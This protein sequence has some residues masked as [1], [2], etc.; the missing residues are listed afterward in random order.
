MCG[1]WG[2]LSLLRNLSSIRSSAFNSFYQ[3]KYRGPDRSHFFELN[4]LHSSINF[5][6]GFHRLAI[7]DTST[8]GDQPFVFEFN[9]HTV[10]T[11]CNGEIFNSHQLIN[12]YNLNLLSHSDCE[13]IPSI[14]QQ[15]G[16]HTLVQDLLGEFACAIFD[17]HSDNTAQIFLFRDPFGVR[18]LFY[19]L[20]DN[21]FAFA[22]EAKAIQDLVTNI[23]PFP[24]GSFACLNISP[25]SNNFDLLFTP[26]YHYTFP[27]LSSLDPFN[28]TYLDSVMHNIVSIFSNAVVCRLDSDRPLGA[29]LSGG[30]DSS[31]VVA[32]ASKYL[33]ETYNKTLHTFSIGLPNSTDEYYAQLVADHCHTIH[34]HIQLDEQQFIDAIPSVIWATETFDIT[35]IRASTGQYLISQWIANNTDIKVLLIGD[36]SDELCSGYLYF[37]NSPSPSDSHLENIKLLKEIHL[38]DVDR[39][40]RGIAHHGIEA[41]VPFLDY[42]FVNYYMSIDPRLRIPINGIEKWLLRT[43]FN[44][45]DYLPK[46]ILFRKKEAFSDGVSSTTKS[47]YQIIQNNA[48]KLYHDNELSSSKYSHCPPPTKEALH[49]RNIFSNLFPNLDHIIPHFWLPNWCGDISEPSARVLDVY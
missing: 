27:I 29:L 25:L 22:S 13:I 48:D 42:R 4:S 32:V 36:G 31:L 6:L 14:Y 28:S 12:K 26:F 40:D 24:P 37:H 11:I 8:N 7:M 1:L 47:W 15:H 34:T 41:R 30:L 49:Y 35:T 3:I 20:D 18:P 21:G 9:N 39:A 19:G 46:Q 16:I 17:F 38:Y 23:H 10:Y 44:H 5:F 2:F 33:K 43:A 45:S